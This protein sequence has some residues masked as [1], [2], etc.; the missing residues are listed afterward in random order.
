MVGK[1][2]G[3]FEI[4]T[5]L[6]SGGM[7]SVYAATDQ[8][9]G[10]RVAIKVLH[11]ECARNPELVTRF[12]NEARAVNIIEHPGIVQISEFSTL[13]DGSPY[14]VMEHLKGQTLE[15]ILSSYPAGLPEAQVVRIGWQL[16]DT[17]VAVHERG[18]VH[19]DR[20]DKHKIWLRNGYK[21]IHRRRP[22]DA[23]LPLPHCP[24]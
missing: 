3:N 24:S 6:G 21:A 11:A 12:F 16:A 1:H 8:Q 23:F 10:R 20:R 13:A 2:I 19:R 9:L 18:I 22:D 17:M 4:T 7:G 5:L 14:L 15:K